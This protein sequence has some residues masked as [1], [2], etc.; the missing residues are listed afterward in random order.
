[1][2]CLQAAGDRD[3]DRDDLTGLVGRAFSE[4][5]LQSTLQILVG[6]HQAAMSGIL[7]CAA[8]SVV[9]EDG[10]LNRAGHLECS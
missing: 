8:N 2:A 5:G 10:S 4:H 9:F 6:Q 1:M 3:R 7:Y